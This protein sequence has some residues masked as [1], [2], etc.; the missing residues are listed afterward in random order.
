M[1]SHIK[2]VTARKAL[3]IG[4]VIAY[5]TEAVFGL[6]CEPM[7]RDA[8]FRILEIKERHVKQ[9]M[10][11]IAS[12]IEQLNDYIHPLDNLGEVRAK[13]IRTSWPGGNTWILPCKASVPYWITGVH[14][15][16][17]VRVTD[18][19][20]ASKICEYYGGPI[21]STS[22][23]VHGREPTRNVFQTFKAFGDYVD[24]I[25]PGTV[26]K[27]KNPSVIR[28]GVTGKVLRG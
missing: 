17:A 2:F 21:V 26:D 1:T 24:Y 11:L 19:P 14:R 8:V 28:D 23:N 13:E 10:I 3:E 16:L 6:G 22:A 15:S 27:E 9:G 5:P 25:V 18:H 4:G 20:I 12:S 7:N